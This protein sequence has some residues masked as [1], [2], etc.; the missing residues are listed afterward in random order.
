M[1]R[2]IKSHL[3]RQKP[4]DPVIVLTMSE[5][6]RSR[7]IATMVDSKGKMEE[8]ENALRDRLGTAQDAEDAAKHLITELRAELYNLRDRK[9]QITSFIETAK[10][11]LSNKPDAK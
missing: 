6:E 2:F 10:T 4:A 8:Q 9:D 3:F 7:F 1:I 5:E 11:H